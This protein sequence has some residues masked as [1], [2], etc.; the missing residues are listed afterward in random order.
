LEV[1]LALAVLLAL[2]YFGITAYT[3]IV[4]AS[5]VEAGAQMIN[6]Q[7]ADARQDAISQNMAV[8]VRLYE[9][10]PVPG[11][12]TAYGSL[13]LRWKESDGTTPPAARPLLLPQAAVID[14][15]AVHSTLVTTNTEPPT[16]DATDLRI[17]PLTRAFHF[18]PNGSTD[19][20]PTG[21]WTLTVRAATQFNPANFPANWACVE[22]DPVTG[23]T[24]IYRP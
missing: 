19:L 18:L 8:E 12:P 21:Q 1:V 11:R 14:A 7:L 2:F 24:Q 22:V 16:A 6:D 5:A 10:A 13:Q 9:T 4:E 17:D 15:T 20:A 23:R 3:R